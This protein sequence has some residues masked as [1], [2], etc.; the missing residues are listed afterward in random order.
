MQLYNACVVPALLYGIQSL[1][2]RKADA[3]KLDAFHCR[4][5]RQVLGIPRPYI[6]HV[7]NEAVLKAAASVPLSSRILEQQLHDYAKVAQMPAGS[8]PRRLL[9]QDDVLAPRTWPGPW[10]RGRPRACWTAGV[11]S[12]ALRVASGDAQRLR[13]WISDVRGAAWRSE[14][15]RHLRT[16]R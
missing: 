3:R 8:A 12:E 7:T 10:R 2:L 11:H 1:W 5:L 14:V 16:Q 9:F 6:S 4:C 15:A 13:D